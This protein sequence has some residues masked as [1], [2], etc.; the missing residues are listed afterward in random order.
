M[1]L[2][3][4]PKSQTENKWGIIRRRLKKVIVIVSVG[5]ILAVSVSYFVNKIN[6]KTEDA[7]IEERLSEGSEQIVI[8]TTEEIQEEKR[9]KQI[10][11]IEKALKEYKKGIIKFN[12]ANFYYKNGNK[13]KAIILFEEARVIFS[14]SRNYSNSLATYAKQNYSLQ[15]PYFIYTEKLKNASD[16]MSVIAGNLK[17][18]SRGIPCV[19]MCDTQIYIDISNENIKDIEYYLSKFGY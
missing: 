8:K 9:Q 19:F 10:K 15:H 14:Y 7:L 12:E 1:F 2:F 18:Y 13:E 16:N 4:W 3:I 11:T 17:D 6:E 5:I